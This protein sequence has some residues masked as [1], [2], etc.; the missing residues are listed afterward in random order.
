MPHLHATP[1]ALVCSARIRIPNRAS[2]CPVE[3]PSGPFADVGTSI[4]TLVLLY[5]T[6][7]SNLAPLLTSHLSPPTSHL[8]HLLTGLASLLPSFLL[9]SSSFTVPLRVSISVYPGLFRQTTI[10]MHLERSSPHG[11][12]RVNPHGIVDFVNISHRRI[13]LARPSATRESTCPTRHT[14]HA[15]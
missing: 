11:I 2:N 5:E 10:L 15:L 12:A 6:L 7:S 13:S 1:L 9:V 3:S 14:P 4:R 8:P